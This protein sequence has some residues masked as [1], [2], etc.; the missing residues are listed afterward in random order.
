MDSG[1]LIL[2]TF[3]AGVALVVVVTL[4][5]FRWFTR[6]PRLRQL[7]EDGAALSESGVEFPSCF[8]LRSIKVSY[9]EIESVDLLP[10]HQSIPP[11][12]LF[13]YGIG[14]SS[15]YTR[16]FHEAVVIKLIRPRVFKYWLVTPRNAPAFA[17]ELRTRIE[18]S[19]TFL[20]QV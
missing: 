8:F 16:L 2:S 12:L 6:S 19:R 20:S 17:K 18:Q 4:K 14:V 5:A 10:F 15:N 9:S 3:L 13:R 1:A 11:A 7:T